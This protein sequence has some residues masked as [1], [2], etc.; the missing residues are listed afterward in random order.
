M[1]RR[2]ALALLSGAAAAPF[3][4]WRDALAQAAP[5]RTLA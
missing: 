4:G 5:G 2:S 1:H 3:A